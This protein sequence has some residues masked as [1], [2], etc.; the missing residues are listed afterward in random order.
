MKKLFFI[1]E[2]LQNRIDLK[3]LFSMYFCCKL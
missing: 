2:I 3:I 1:F